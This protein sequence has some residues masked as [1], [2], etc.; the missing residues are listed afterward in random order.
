MKPYLPFL[1]ICAG[2][3]SLTAAAKTRTMVV[4]TSSSE[5]KSIELSMQTRITFSKDLAEMNVTVANETQT[6]D[7]D[8]IVNIV[9]TIDSTT[10]LAEQDL[11]DLK[12]SHSAGIVTISGPGDIEYS[13]WNMSGIKVAEGYGNQLV[14]VDL[15]T[16]SP[17]VYIIKANNKTLKFIKH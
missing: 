12:I 15:S 4:T 16:M 5:V 2:L 13:V 1:A 6:F 9:F 3:L 17:D 8:D 11:D 10:D 7:V 14:T